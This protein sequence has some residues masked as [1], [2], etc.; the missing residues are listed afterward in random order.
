MAFFL[1]IAS[2]FLLFNNNPYYGLIFASFASIT[3]ALL[4]LILIIILR[5]LRTTDRFHAEMPDMQTELQQQYF[6]NIKQSATI[7]IYYA[8]TV[9]LFTHVSINMFDDGNAETGKIYAVFALIPIVLFTWGLITTL[10]RLNTGRP[11]NKD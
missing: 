3:I 5:K 2:I 11:T 6:T 9:A 10:R 7:I 1:G 4:I 8:L